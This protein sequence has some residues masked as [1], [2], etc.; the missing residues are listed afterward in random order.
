MWR[1]STIVKVNIASRL[2]TK[3]WYVMKK[4]QIKCLRKKKA[5]SHY[6]DFRVTWYHHNGK[7][8]TSSPYYFNILFRQLVKIDH[9]IHHRAHTAEQP[10]PLFTSVLIWNLY[11]K[12]ELI[13]YN[14]YHKHI[15]VIEFL[16][17]RD[18]SKTLY[19]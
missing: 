8:V 7:L 10:L 17:A 2:W 1:C 15:T 3:G 12:P 6:S 5:I 4:Q 14:N 13:S 9:H 16:C 18:C 19:V 11:P